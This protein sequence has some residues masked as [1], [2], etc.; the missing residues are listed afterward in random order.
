MPNISRL[1]TRQK[2]EEWNTSRV[3]VNLAKRDKDTRILNW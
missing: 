3:G 2:T 1:K